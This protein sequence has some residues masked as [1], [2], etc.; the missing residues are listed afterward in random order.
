MD[1]TLVA[2]SN[3]GTLND[4]AARFCNNCGHA[5]SATCGVCGT[6]NPATAKFCFHC[7][8]PFL[9]DASG[10]HPPPVAGAQP[11]TQPIAELR[12]VSVLFADLVGFTTLAEGRD[13]EETREL[14]SRYFEISQQVIQRHGGVIEKFI[15]DA[16]MAVWGAPTAHEDDA[17]RAVRAA[18]ELVTEVPSLGD[19]A[20]PVQARAGVLT[21]E[22]AVTIGASNQGMV[23]GDLVN[24]ASRLQSAAA[25]GTVLV[26][27]ATMHAASTSIMFEPAGE[28]A[29]KGKAAPV[30]AW[31]AITVVARRG[32]S[33]RSALLEPPFV[34]RDDELSLLKDLFDATARERKSRLVSVVGQAG[35][36]KSRLAWEFEKYLDG[37]VDTA[38]WHEGRSPSYGEGISYW[39]LAEMV[40]R[41]CGIAETDDEATIRRRLGATLD[42]FVV[43]AAERRWIEPR[44]AGLLGLSELPTE[45]REELFSAW[46]TFF[47]RM[48]GVAPVILVFT[49]LQWADQGMLDFV[50]DLLR[51]SRNSPIFVV[52]LARPELLERRSDFGAS[53]R[54]V[55]RI[56][57][58]PLP[59]DVMRKL[60]EGVVPG[61]PPIALRAMVQRAEGIPLYA[62]E[63][64]RMLLDRGL[65]TPVD[66]RYHV[67][68]DLGQLGVAETLHALIASRLDDNLPEDRALMLDASV[69][70][71][72][73][74]VEALA[75]VAG[76]S[77]AEL[78]PQL[79][80][81]TRRELVTLIADPRSPDRG[82][83][84]FVQALVREV[85]YQ[86]L[87]KP[88]RRVRHLA[89]ARFFET[90]GSDELAGVLATHYVAA[91]QASRPGAEADA[92]AAQARVA[93]QGA[94]ERAASLHSMRQAAAY[95]DQALLVTT[96]PAEQASIHL[97][98]GE[99][100]EETG[101]L[102]AA[103]R[104]AGDARDL[105]RALADA[106]GALRAA[107]WLGRHQT[108]ARVELQAIKTFEEAL[109]EAE[110]I[111]DSAEYAAA[112]AELSRVYMLVSRSAEAVTTAD[113]AMELGGRHGLVSPVIEAMINRGTAL[114]GLGRR[115]EATGTLQGAIALAD[116]Y[117]LRPAS[118]RARNN[119]MGSD[120]DMTVNVTQAREMYEMAV[121]YGM[122]GGWINQA[123]MMGAANAFTTGDWD[124]WMDRIAAMEE[125]E[126]PHAFWRGGFAYA[127]SVRAALR[128]NDAEADA[129]MRVLEEI[130]GSLQSPMVDAS[131]LNVQAWIEFARAQWT[132]AARDGLAAAADFNQTVEGGTVAAHAAAAGGLRDE[133]EAAIG[134][135]TRLRDVA[136][137]P[138]ILAQARAALAARDGRWA[139]ARAGYQEAMDL[140]AVTGSWT[141]HATTALE[142]GEMGR[143]HDD[144]AAVAADLAEQFFAERGARTFVERYRTGFVPVP[145][146]AAAPKPA[147]A[148][149]PAPASVPDA[150]P[151]P[152]TEG[153]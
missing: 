114:L 6:V 76:R 128:G 7:G 42:E 153:A 36:G 55:T 139:E 98:A 104:H 74:T 17:E 67:T 77:A 75:A 44:L 18:L 137:A 135:I 127:R 32:G 92:L 84:Q 97:R 2:C 40:R 106:P 132:D 48:A 60:L 111:N 61:L 27:E 73:F 117:G 65:L 39:A 152:A 21:G 85:A 5:M 140:H 64:V 122:T 16:V 62:V 68:G 89:A 149:S 129:Q 43:D 110:P 33:G 148:P 151:A 20:H 144:T 113:R 19:E 101:D 86:N 107:T 124:G 46:R 15:G 50:E 109:A 9:T 141:D 29:L 30:A 49:D 100:G 38:Y 145:A 35:M 80:R 59:D 119:L 150:E 95:L 120:D 54:S 1:P 31:R 126:Q 88:D 103:I 79:E 69:L 13:P 115:V 136:G 47:E 146:P 133:L 4:P 118:L 96:D 63:T 57:L 116:R 14:L 10:P 22:A 102:D 99:V 66:G 81:L 41:R 12:L 90:L 130:H 53:V 70:G 26:G 143:G 94:A 23:A 108:S 71:Q 72:S 142:W 8:S 134:A 28:Q 83:Y 121:R 91:Y 37:V 34:G 45:G 11:G 78:T 51:W 56:N 105:F 112:L 138:P 87:A 123:L 125:I 131:G 25:P 93:L 3:C 82:Q 52:A 24:T 58:E 147:R